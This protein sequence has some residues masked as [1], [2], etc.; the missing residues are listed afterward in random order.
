MFKPL[1]LRELEIRNRI[2][3][4]PMCQVCCAVCC[5]CMCACGKPAGKG[6]CQLPS[7]REMGSLARLRN[8]T[9]FAFGKS[10]GK[11]K[12]DIAIEPG[13]GAIDP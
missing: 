8:D 5:V 3:I 6:S 4:S 2:F 12:A 7:N 9:M 11:K 13:D 1:K 10:E